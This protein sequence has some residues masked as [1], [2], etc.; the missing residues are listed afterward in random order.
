M[1]FRGKGAGRTQ[2]KCNRGEEPPQTSMGD[3][4]YIIYGAKGRAGT[5]DGDN[6][7]TDKGIASMK[8]VT[9]TVE[10]KSD[11]GTYCHKQA[12][13]CRAPRSQCGKSWSP[14][15]LFYSPFDWSPFPRDHFSTESF[16]S[17]H[18]DLLPL[19]KQSMYFFCG[20]NAGASAI[21]MQ[22]VNPEYATLANATGCSATMKVPV[23]GNYRSCASTIVEQL[24]LAADPSKKQSPVMSA[25]TDAV[26]AHGQGGVNKTLELLVAAEGFFASTDEEPSAYSAAPYYNVTTDTLQWAGVL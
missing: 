5:P 21:E 26:S 25:Y 3:I 16:K 14:L 8:R 22:V 12:N 1:C 23:W 6:V 19:V 4:L 11:F 7:F 9:D 17:T 20:A 15:L 18:V 10:G 2:R 24:K 13:Q